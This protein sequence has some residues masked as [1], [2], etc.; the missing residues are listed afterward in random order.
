MGGE[1]EVME[2]FGKRGRRETFDNIK[3]RH[4]RREENKEKDKET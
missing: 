3:L 1:N 4:Y 2:G